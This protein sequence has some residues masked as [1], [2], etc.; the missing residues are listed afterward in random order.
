MNKFAAIAIAAAVATTAGL[1]NTSP[2]EAGGRHHFGGHF[3]IHFYGPHYGHGYYHGGP[4]YY[5]GKVCGY[6]WK[7]RW[8]NRKGRY[9][10]FRKRICWYR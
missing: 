9:I 7:R 2:A 10:K 8:S 5:G 1:A 6:K 3:G 4:Y